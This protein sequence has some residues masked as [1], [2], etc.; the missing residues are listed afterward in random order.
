[1]SL[2]SNQPADVLYFSMDD[3]AE[4]MGRNS[5]HPFQLEDALWPTIEHYYQALKFDKTQ[6]QIKILGAATAAQAKALGNARF[7]RK[8]RDFKDVR[9]TLM[10]RAVYTQAKTY[11]AIAERILQTDSR[12]LVEN[13]QFDYYWGCGRDHRGENHYGQVVMN[14]R[15]KLQDESA[16]QS[17][18]L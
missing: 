15:G 11:N 2:F 14:V 18:I 8:R 4:L 3:P 17:P 12:K 6:Y 16:G 9:T 10:T 5:P 1:M 7:K 13:S